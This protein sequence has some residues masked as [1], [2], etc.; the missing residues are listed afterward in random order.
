[1]RIGLTG[2][3]GS[4]KSTVAK[5]FQSLGVPVYFADEEARK[6][7]T[8]EDFV[9]QMVHRWGDGVVTHGQVNRKFIASII[10]SDELELEWMNSQI[11]PLVRKDFLEWVERQNAPYIIQEAAILFESGFQTLF[12]AVIT[13][14][15]DAEE[16]L[17]RVMAR[18]GSKPEDVH[19]RMQKQWTE[20][21]RQQAA[22][23][24][25]HNNETDKVLP[26]VLKLHENLLSQSGR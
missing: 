21:Q 18:D 3:I 11:H 4:G 23:Y 7:L 12:D 25:I 13:V 9:K 17:Q 5:A 24:I 19:A 14:A 15:A 2:G 16:R 1:M 8:N 10:F 20:A 26:Q 22:D 6:F